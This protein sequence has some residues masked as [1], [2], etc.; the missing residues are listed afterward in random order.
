ER[1]KKQESEL[2]QKVED[3]LRAADEADAAED[4]RYGKGKRGDELPEDLRRAES[5]IARIRAANAALEAEARTQLEAEKEKEKRD[6]DE[7]PGGGA[8]PLPQHRI[9][10]DAEGKPTPKAQRNFTDAESRIQKTGDG[11]VQGYN[12]QAAVA[13]GHQIIVAQAVTDQPPDVEHLTPMLEQVVANCGAAPEKTT[14]DAG[15]FSA[16]NVANAT[17]LGTDPFIAPGRWKRGE[18][19]SEL[20]GP[21]PADMTPK[22][23]MARKLA[24]P[25]D[26]AAYA[27]RKA[28]VEPVF[29]QIKQARGLRQFLMRGLANVRAEWS[30]ITLTH[31]V[32]KLHAATVAA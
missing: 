12:C 11:F 17:S 24:T 5:R 8:T 19:P 14:A 26:A 10:R 30:L 3:L 27:R 18:E 29:G 20:L 6:D 16:Q 23:A 4:A 21:P 13:E 7:P 32:L 9:P 15:Y 28:V 2:A 1:M 31:N 22:Q 25:T